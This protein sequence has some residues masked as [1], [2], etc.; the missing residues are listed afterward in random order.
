MTV[1]SFLSK[2]LGSGTAIEDVDVDKVYNER[3]ARNTLLSYR[4]YWRKYA[5]IANPASKPMRYAQGSGMNKKPAKTKEQH[6]S[7]VSMRIPIPLPERGI[8][9]YVTCPV[10]INAQEAELIGNVLSAY[11]I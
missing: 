5:K 10:N 4:H 3:V 6:V 9:V 1:L 7:C 8:V 2:N 11:A